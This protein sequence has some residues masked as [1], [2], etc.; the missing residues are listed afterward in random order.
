MPLCLIKEN[1]VVP[2]DEALNEVEVAF[3]TE[4][5]KEIEMAVKMWA[6]KVSFKMLSVVEVLLEV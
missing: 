6:L 4:L 2:E 5:L 1:E 3:L